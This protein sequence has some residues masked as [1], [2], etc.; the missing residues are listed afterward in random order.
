MFDK[1][2]KRDCGCHGW[3]VI[4]YI[5]CCCDANKKEMPCVGKFCYLLPYLVTKSTLRNPIIFV[6]EIAA[7]GELYIHWNSIIK[8]LFG[9][10]LLRNNRNSQRLLCKFSVLLLRRK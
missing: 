4:K 6:S 3:N 9:F 7:G 8:V 2:M 5:E 10:P 1:W